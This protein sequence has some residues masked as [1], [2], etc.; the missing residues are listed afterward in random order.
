MRGYDCG[1]CA[2]AVGAVFGVSSE[3]I[4]VLITFMRRGVVFVGA[5]IL[6]ASVSWAQPAASGAVLV[7]GPGGQITSADLD[8]AVREMVPPERRAEFWKQPEAV[9]RLARSLYTQRAL[10]RTA[11]AEG[12]DKTAQA[13]RYLRYTR[14]RALTELLMQQRVAQATP[15]EQAQQAYVRSEYQA[16]PDKY[17]QPEQ[18]HVRHILL[19][20]AKDGSDAAAVKTRIEA[21]RSELL[22]G[23]DFVEAAKKHSQDDGNASTGGD[24]GFITKGRMMEPFDAAAFSLK[25]PGQIS[26]PVRTS[27]GYHLIQLVEH[28]A[29]RPIPM[30]DVQADIRAQLLNKLNAET[31]ARIWETADTD[32]KVDEQAVKALADRESKR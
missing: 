29:R 18:A 7:S 30:A 8:L 16:H 15:T 9:S 26:E 17:T 5:A 21:L 27:F 31:R 2:I 10:A 14:E 13:E 1:F 25:K 3:R 12:V 22:K 20:V 32:A 11:E 28:K 19:R 24:M 4:F 23:G 6:A